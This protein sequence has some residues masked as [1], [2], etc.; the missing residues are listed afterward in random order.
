MCLE[1]AIPPFVGYVMY[2][3]L[4]WPTFLIKGDVVVYDKACTLKAHCVI[5]RLDYLLN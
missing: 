1:G 4:M 5:A 3:D 2:V